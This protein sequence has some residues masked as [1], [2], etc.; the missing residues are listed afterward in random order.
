[1]ARVLVVADTVPALHVELVADDETANWD[2]PCS[3]CGWTVSENNTRFN[4]L[5]DAVHTAIVHLDHQ[6]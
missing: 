3:G 5:A 4:D 6:H 1:M 2:G